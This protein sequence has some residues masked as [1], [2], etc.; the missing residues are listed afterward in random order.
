[1]GIAMCVECTMY[2][3]YVQYSRDNN[4]EIKYFCS[5]QDQSLK[6]VSLWQN[7]GHFDQ[8]DFCFVTVCKI[9]IVKRNGYSNYKF[10]YSLITF[11][12]FEIFFSRCSLEE[13]VDKTV[14]KIKK[15]RYSKNF[16]KV[17]QFWRNEY[18]RVTSSCY[19]EKIIKILEYCIFF[20]RRYVTKRL[21]VHSIML[22][23]WSLVVNIKSLRST[24]DLNSI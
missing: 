15:F 3:S 23:F 12:Y 24:H 4:F 5:V 8:S 9:V 13:T 16:T 7:C 2:S 20:V 14:D 22:S 21:W 11:Y 6:L 17:R 18:F 19:S 10:Q 1:M